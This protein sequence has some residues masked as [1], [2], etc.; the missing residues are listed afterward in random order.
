MTSTLPTFEEIEAFLVE[1]PNSN[2]C[3]IRDHFNQHGIYISR[4]APDMPVDI[5]PD[6]YIHLQEFMKQDHVKLKLHEYA[7]MH[8][9]HTHD[10]KDFP[11]IPIAL[12][13]EYTQ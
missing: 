5:N 9:Y 13:I 6:F 11:F 12:Y 10:P 1:N 7:Y 3:K 2:I 8:L 4:T